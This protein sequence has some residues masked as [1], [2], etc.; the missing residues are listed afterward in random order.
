MTTQASYVWK[1]ISN[2]PDDVSAVANSE[3]RSLA[4]VWLEQKDG[5]LSSGA[6]DDFN[7]RLK[8]QWAIETGIIERVYTLDRGTTQLL[9][10]KGIDS[11]L[12]PSSATDRNPEL[13]A[14]M[15][16][17]HQDAVEG[18]FAAVKGQ[19]PLSTSYVKELHA[20]LTRHQETVTAV[21]SLGRTVE[22]PLIRGEYKKQPNN[23]TRSNGAVHE[24]CPPEQVSSEMDRLV[25]L[26]CKH[27]SDGVPPEVQAAWLHH[28]F[29]Q[30]HPFQD[31][32]GRVARALASMVLIKADWFPLTITEDDGHERYV[33]A[34]EA[35]D[36]GDFRT[37]VSF[38]ASILKRTFVTA[39]SIAGQVQRRQQ[40]D[41]VI[42]AARDVL[43]KRRQALY[44]KWE[45]AK[46]TA[47]KLQSL[48]VEHLDQ[49][50]QKLTQEIG[51]FS[52]EFAFWVD[53]E[54]DLGSRAHYFR[55]QIIET[56]RGLHYFA[57]IGEYHAWARLVLKTK[58]QAEVLISFHGIGHEYRGLLAVTMCFYRREETE[59]KER[60]MG[61]IFSVSDEMFQI[62]YQ[63]DPEEVQ[64]RFGEWL[65]Q[66][67]VKALE[68]WRA[69][70]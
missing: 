6:L 11:S 38:T 61:K 52:T 51:A 10:E 68:I 32:N 58:E 12:I 27:S 4:S 5:L 60:Q 9:I 48:A 25:E 24:Y 18:I 49:V 50:Q 39:L 45:K 65:D 66:G 42:T 47:A 13:V 30:I 54:Q 17:D 26:H 14:A 56:A 44:Q 22:V 34:L 40:V 31:G 7:E 43:E 69:G 19:R 53:K 2:L 70:L 21:D 35:A 63:E 41:Q 67:L 3:L 33:E 46:N 15:I 55:H 59:E 57:N 28:A 23:P 20:V 8:R 64:D 29:T 36:Q 1:P 16:G 62:N 37:F